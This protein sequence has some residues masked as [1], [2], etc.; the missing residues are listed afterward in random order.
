MNKRDLAEYIQE[1]IENKTMSKV[2]W[3]EGM[4]NYYFK[5]RHTGLAGISNDMVVDQC[6]SEI[7]NLRIW[8]EIEL[9]TKL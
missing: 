9:R 6:R 4:V 7:R 2:C 3:H 8:R 1:R 5:N